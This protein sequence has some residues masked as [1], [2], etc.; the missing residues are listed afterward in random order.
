MASA[1]V[2]PSSCNMP[3]KRSLANTAP[4]VK[5]I[6]STPPKTNDW[7]VTRLAIGQS[8]PPTKRAVIATA[9][10]DTMPNR[11]VSIHNA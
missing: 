6:A 3:A 1:A 4:V 8:P 5:A 9:P 2:S 10:I 7:F 11:L